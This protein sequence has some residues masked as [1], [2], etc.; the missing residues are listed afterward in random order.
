[1]F[2][3]EIRREFAGTPA[4]ECYQACLRAV[5]AAGYKIVKKRD[6]ASLAICQS[7]L[8][9]SPVD[10]SLMVPLG[11]PTGVILTISS[12]RAD[13]AS[14]KQEADRVLGIVGNELGRS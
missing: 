8:Q 11:K 7:I 1:M 12:E 14:L 6:I 4:N 3:H 9:G 10:L 2:K 5:Q 13:E